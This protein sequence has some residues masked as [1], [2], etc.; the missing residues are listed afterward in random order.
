MSEVVTSAVILAGGLGTRLRDTVP[1]VP[2]PMAPVNGRP[3]LEH[4]IDYWIGQ[5]IGHFI[6][7]VGYLREV[8]MEHFGT[9]YRNAR[10]DYAV[11]N[12]PLGT[13]GGLL[14]AVDRLVDQKSFLLLN[15]DTFFEVNLDELVGFH[16]SSQSDWTISLF[17]TSDTGR[18]M[19]LEVAADGRIL[20]LRSAAGQPRWLANG[21]VYLVRPELLSASAWK[22]GIRLS[23]EDDIM[24]ALIERGARFYG[25]ECEGRFIDIGVPE[26]Y[27]RS[28]TLLVA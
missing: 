9:S 8:I 11:E 13:G 23:L 18:Y 21:G 2:K 20:S 19:G 12:T 4:Q 5:G 1:D 28:A 27:L 14:L 3:F 26:D 10:I 17:A 7:S 6:L 15:G 22:P 25:H 24:P 16:T